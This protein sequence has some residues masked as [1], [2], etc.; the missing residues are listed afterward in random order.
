LSQSAGSVVAT[1]CRVE[2]S[3]EILNIATQALVV[4]LPGVIVTLY[5]TGLALFVLF[6]ETPKV[7]Q[8]CISEQVVMF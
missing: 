4:L 5:N 6:V 2:K 7:C 1:S 3:L 8:A